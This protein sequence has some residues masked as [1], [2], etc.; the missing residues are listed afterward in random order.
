MEMKGRR[1][2]RQ[3]SFGYT[4]LEIA[5]ASTVM[6]VLSL[7]CMEF[8]DENTKLHV[9]NVTKVDMERR[10]QFAIDNIVNDLKETNPAKVQ[11][12]DFQD[13]PG[14][15]WQ[16][17]I[18]FPTARD[19]TGE[20]IFTNGG[21]VQSEPVWQGI[22]VYAFYGPTANEPGRLMKF[23]DYTPGRS[24]TNP[25]EVASITDTQI[26]LNDNLGTTFDRTTKSV[27][28]VQHRL[29]LMEDLA[30]LVR[31]EPDPPAAMQLPLI[32]KLVAQKEISELGGEDIQV[33]SSTGVLSR[34]EN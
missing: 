3:N 9:L 11:V 23:V 33:M 25:I 1:M 28:G 5:L 19:D 32:L 12:W 24:Y 16:T 26:V 4:L 20:F 10:L 14:N 31:E 34:N 13:G 7:L 21:E 17:A 29:I 27:A 8:M 15:V 22:A 18:V 30:Q 2:E 6:A